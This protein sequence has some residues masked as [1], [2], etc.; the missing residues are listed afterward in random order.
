MKPHFPNQIWAPNYYSPEVAVIHLKG[1]QKDMTLASKGNNLAD[2]AVK[3][4][5]QNK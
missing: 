4:A 2:H 1:H 3:Q 5:A